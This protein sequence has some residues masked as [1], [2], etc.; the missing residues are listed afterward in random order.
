MLQDIAILTGGQVI[1]S[2]LG[3]EL[4]D[5]DITMLGT[6]RQVKVSKEN[7]IIVDGA[8][9]PGDIKDRIAQINNEI[10]A[11]SSEYDKEKLQ[12]RLA[13][14]AGGV[15]V[16]KVGA[17]TEVEMKDKKLRIEDALNA[18]RA[19]VEEGIVAGG[20][21]SFVKASLAVEKLLETSQGDEKTGIAVVAKALMAP[22][23]QI[24]ANAGVEG[25]IIL[26]KVKTADKANFGYD[27]AA[28]TYCDMVESGITDPTKVCRSALENAA[29]I[30]AMV[31]TTESLV[32]DIPEPPAAAAAGAP[33]MGGGMGMY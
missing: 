30:A 19:A 14:L 21:T 33:D 13:K 29:S 28:G 16:I 6:A 31:L 20:G 5:T 8:G 25:A 1:S 10:E 26:D 27:A 3:M 32:T 7:T 15:A 23:Q 22:I 4:K 12:E 17:A 9:A 18:T 2:D 11:T 24:A